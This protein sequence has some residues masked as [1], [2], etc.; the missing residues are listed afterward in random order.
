M[1]LQVTFQNLSHQGIESSPSGG[2]ALENIAAVGFGLEGSL[3]RLDLTSNSANS[4]E[5]LRFLFDGVAHISSPYVKKR[6]IPYL[7][8]GMGL[9]QGC[10]MGMD[11]SLGEASTR[12]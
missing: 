1:L 5:K 8:M 2:H 12:E 3:N 7:G 4:I 6:Q 9:T 11:S 10:I